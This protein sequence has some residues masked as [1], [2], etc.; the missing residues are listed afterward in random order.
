MRSI[1]FL[2]LPL[3]EFT[4]PRYVRVNTNLLSR[5]EAM[6]IFIKDGWHE[7]PSSECETYDRFL[8]VVRNLGEYDFVSDIHVKNLFVFPASSK[9]FWARNSLVLESKLILQDKVS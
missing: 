3:T 4:K 5:S 8:E 1:S 7:I 9:R 6:E 2:L